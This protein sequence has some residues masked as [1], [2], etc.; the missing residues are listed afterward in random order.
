MRE[1]TDMGQPPTHASR[2]PYLSV[3]VTTRNDDHGGDPLKRLQAFVNAFDEQA[4]RTG[5]DA[6]VIV[7][8]WNPPPERPTVGAMLRLPDPSWCTYRFVEVPPELHAGLRHADVLPLFQMIAK[9]VGIRRASG[10]FILATNID[11]IFSMELV[12]YLGSQPLQPGYLYRVDRHDIQADLPV[13]APVETQLAWAASHQLRVHTRN[14]SYPVDANGRHL[15]LAE[16]IVDGRT[17]RL[18][19]GWHVRE[20]GGGVPSYRWA[21]DRVALIVDR[22]IVPTVYPPLLALEV[23]AN[24]YDPRAWVRVEILDGDR[25]VSRAHIVGRMR[26]EVPLDHPGPDGRHVIE[27]RV[28]ETYANAR[29][30][31]PIFERRDT[32]QYRVYSSEVRPSSLEQPGMFE[33]PASGWVNAHPG[34]ALTIE[35]TA[36][37]LRVASDPRK[38][39]YCVEYGPLRAPASGSY[40]FEIACSVLDGRVKPGVL[41]G[42]RHFWMPASIEMHHHPRSLRFDIRVELRRHELFWLMLFNDHPDG[43]GVSRFVVHGLT[44]SAAPASLFAERRSRTRTTRF[45]ERCVFAYVNALSRMRR[46]WPDRAALARRTRERLIA[47]G[48][49]GARFISAVLGERMRR[50][51]VRAAPEYR[52][53]ERALRVSDEQL[54]AVSPL[55]D[56]APLHR[57]LHE[58]RPTNLHVNGCGD[59]Q[60]MAR[61][62]WHE[63]RGYPE[64]ETFS[65]NIDGLFSYIAEAAGVKE[66]ALTMPIYHIEHEVGSGWSPEGEALL[67]RRIAERGITWLDATTVYVWAAYMRW[68]QRPMIFNGPD[69]GMGDARLPEPTARDSCRASA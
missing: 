41:S 34:S 49:Q 45:V 14:G 7:V 22:T 54:R 11:I 56:L 1:P 42:G 16:D 30:Q 13:D 23:E 51:I 31:L 66:Q 46:W 63:L 24:P 33:Y 25:T 20:G 39:A 57:F 8:E 67:R 12:E 65:M 47:C 26:L 52:S 36:E 6:E 29:Q 53:L 61:E 3:V 40:R 35:A 17:I 5:L 38:W 28:T 21:S 48:D 10:R 27:L 9:N 32:M 19:D 58:R 4:R 37:G 15:G 55:R 60:L 64:F 44:G 62:H 43:D 2:E 18:G 69:W 68:L 50:R 59:F